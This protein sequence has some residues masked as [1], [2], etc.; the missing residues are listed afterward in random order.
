M[1][2]NKLRQRLSFSATPRVPSIFRSRVREVKKDPF[3]VL[4]SQIPNLI[5]MIL[6]SAILYMTFISGDTQTAGNM[7]YESI[8]FGA[9]SRAS[10][11]LEITDEETG[12]PLGGKRAAIQ[13]YFSAINSA[14]GGEETG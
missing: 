8:K 9:E 6:V 7:K 3:D 2:L 1:T 4:I 12:L 11:W 14:S 5:T 10:R 13:F